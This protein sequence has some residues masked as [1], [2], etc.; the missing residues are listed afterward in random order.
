MPI[1]QYKRD[2]CER[3]AK[4][5][6]KSEFAA[7]LAH[8]AEEHEREIERAREEERRAAQLGRENEKLKL[9]EERERLDVV[10]AAI[11]HVLLSRG[12]EVSDKQLTMLL[13]N[14]VPKEERD[15]LRAPGEV[16]Q[17]ILDNCEAITEE[18]GGAH[19]A[20]SYDDL[21]SAL[22]AAIGDRE[23]L[24]KLVGL[25]DFEWAARGGASYADIE[26]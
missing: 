1:S 21:Q 14:A 3:V 17:E 15:A 11:R 10:R 19:G 8:L 18:F 9:R 20:P 23:E 6:K 13:R 5:L 12:H 4:R 16:L 24:L 26:P 2:E 7:Y 25:T 22:D